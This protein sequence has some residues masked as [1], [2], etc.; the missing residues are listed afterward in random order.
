METEIRA[1]LE[2]A[3]LLAVDLHVDAWTLCTEWAQRSLRFIEEGRFAA[4]RRFADRVLREVGL[5]PA[6][7]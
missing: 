2:R 3:A 1:D 5:L 6:E 7:V 4:A